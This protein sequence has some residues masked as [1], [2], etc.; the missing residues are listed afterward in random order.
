MAE[1]IDMP[2]IISAEMQ[3][4][5]DSVATERKWHRLCKQWREEGRIK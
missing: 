3:H 5:I 4:E 1:P 2:G